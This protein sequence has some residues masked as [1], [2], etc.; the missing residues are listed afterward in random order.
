MK[1]CPLPE[2]VHSIADLS[3]FIIALRDDYLAHQD[4]WD[5]VSLEDCFESMAAWITDAEESCAKN[6]EPPLS[7]L[8]PAELCANVL[9]AAKIYE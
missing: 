5:N 2:T 8:S 9:Y 1:K 7:L 4:E 6:N 3:R